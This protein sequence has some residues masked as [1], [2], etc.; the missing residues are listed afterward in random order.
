MLVT[1]R[2]V[3]VSLMRNP[4]L[5]VWAVGLPLVLSV[6]FI[7]MFDSLERND[8]LGKISVVVVR[9][10][11]GEAAVGDVSSEEEA[12]FLQ[13]IEAVSGDDGDEGLLSVT[14]AATEGE[15]QRLVTDSQGEDDPF[16]GYLVFQEGEPR[17][18]L[19]PSAQTVAD[20]AKGSIV[21][22]MLDQYVSRANLIR[23]IVE[24]DPAQL[25]NGRLIEAL[26]S[27]FEATERISVTENPLSEKVR[28]YF[29]LLGLAALNCASMGMVAV[30]G[31]RGCSGPLGARRTVGGVSHGRALAGT[32]LA[33]WAASFV[34]LL[35]V[36]LF[37]SLTVDFG[38]RVAGCV[39]VLLV[40]SLAA[41]SLGCAVAVIPKLPESARSGII[42]TVACMSALFTGLYGQPTMELADQVARA[43]PAST[44]VNPAAQ[45]SEA[46]Y[47]LLYY[48]SF[49][50][51]LGHL[52]I[53]L[54]MTAILFALSARA[55]RRQRYASL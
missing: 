10:D 9:D 49:M 27:P 53:L 8:A 46:F 26:S 5:L 7:F 45:I 37:M 40:A 35:V 21:V 30:S 1:F 11:A 41:V 39:A 4:G 23:G 25:A 48:D 43:F 22:L 31:L 38:D 17:A 16:V 36:F 13:F 34:C 20:Q 42:T 24:T 50:P 51:A 32:L 12:A 29:A 28:Y 33:S 19:Y 54:V 44:L 6:M 3:F 55:L 52:G 14:Y 2:A 47:G 15:A 18:F